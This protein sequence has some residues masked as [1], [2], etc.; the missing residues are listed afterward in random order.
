MP[1]AIDFRGAFCSYP[2]FRNP[3]LFI[4]CRRATHLRELQLP[5]VC[6]ACWCALSPSPSISLSSS[7][8]LSASIPPLSHTHCVS[9]RDA[10]HPVFKASKNSFRMNTRPWSR[11]RRD[12]HVQGLRDDHRAHLCCQGAGLVIEFGV[13][14]Q[15]TTPEWMYIRGFSE[16]P[17]V[18]S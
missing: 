3:I 7:L 10:L 14:L 4:T 13:G 5:P 1:H 18:S 2:S 6:R 12:D 16:S 9:T 11:A 15:S 17:S 8:S